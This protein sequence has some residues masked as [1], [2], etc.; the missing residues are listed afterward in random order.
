M[1][2]FQH[3]Y[4]SELLVNAYSYHKVCVCG[5]NIQSHIL[6]WCLD[7]PLI[8]KVIGTSVMN[9]DELL[10]MPITPSYHKPGARRPAPGFLQLILCGSSVCVCVCVSTPRLLITI[11]MMW[12]DIDSI[13]LV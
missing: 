1:G 12:H 8:I 11:G 13:Q 6:L 9:F 10:N 3:Q 7:V 2:N 5:S 4:L